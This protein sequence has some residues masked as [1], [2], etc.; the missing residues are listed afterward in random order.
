MGSYIYYIY[1][2]YKKE[3]FLSNFCVDTNEKGYGMILAGIYM[4]LI[5]IQN[6]FINVII[7][8]NNENS[9]NYA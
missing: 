2:K 9:K 5:E 3:P 6:S 1:Y 4:A 7:N 8:S